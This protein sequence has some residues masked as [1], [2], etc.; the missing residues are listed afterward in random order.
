M[1]IRRNKKLVVY[2]FILILPLV[3]LLSHQTIS[4]PIRMRIVDF[5][6][7][8]VQI[9]LF[10]F[11]EIKK[12]LFYHNTDSKYRK[13]KGEVETLKGK[14]LQAGEALSENKRL[15][16]LLDLKGKSPLTMMA[17]NV[18]GRDPSNW[19]TTIILDR[20][21]R[22][23]IKQGMP[24]V[25]TAS[26]IGKILEVG[27]NTS[28][29]MLLND[30]NFSVAAVIE[31][32]REEGL[33]SGTL[34]GDCRMRYLSSQADI[35]IGDKVMTSGIS[36]SFPQGLLIGEVIRMEENQSSPTVECLVL[37][38]VSLS[39]LETVLIIKNN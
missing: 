24:V 5:V 1:F 2:L 27:K 9:V 39:Q 38:A 16:E 3:F 22:D 4:I 32:S 29:V 21:E 26:V 11:Q 34:K 6:S 12:I 13:L 15:K 36:S 20:G 17:A 35:R 18:I 10:P 14:L 23:G 7:L 8:P 28:K 25:D 37:P 33:I 19:N 31:R 30:P